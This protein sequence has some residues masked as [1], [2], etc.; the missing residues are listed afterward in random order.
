MGF[1]ALEKAQDRVNRESL[2]LFLR[3]YDVGGKPLN[4]IKIMYANSL[5]YLGVKRG[6]NDC[7]RIKSGGRQ[8][9]IMVLWLFNVYRNSV[10]K[11]GM[12]E[13]KIWFLEK[14]REWG[15]P[16]LLY[17]DNLVLCGE[18]EEDLKMRVGRFVVVCRR[19]DLKV[20][21]I[22]AR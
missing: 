16:G 6:E 5:A 4:V 7:F 17:A 9:C 1:M 8:C 21:A 22:R 13:D 15:L 19:R 20:S 12:G 2:W 11:E 3:M 14:G 10:I 18:S